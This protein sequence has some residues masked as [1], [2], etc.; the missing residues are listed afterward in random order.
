[1]LVNVN[2]DIRHGLSL[3]FGW[4]E[5]LPVGFVLGG[6]GW[7]LGVLAC[8]FCGVGWVLGDDDES[9][10]RRAEARAALL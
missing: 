5:D 7:V 10:P 4:Q 1:M 3:C 9:V 8:G 6:V 2:G